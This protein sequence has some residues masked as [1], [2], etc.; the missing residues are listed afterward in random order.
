MKQKF[1]QMAGMDADNIPSYLD[2]FMWKMS[3]G[4]AYDAEMAFQAILAQMGELWPWEEQ[5]TQEWATPSNDV[6]INVEN[7]K[8]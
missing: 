3:H 6:I 2:E 4:R 1:K 7:V 8:H 5:D